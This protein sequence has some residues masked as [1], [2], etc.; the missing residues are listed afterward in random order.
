VGSVDRFE[1]F[2]GGRFELGVAL[3]AIGVPDFDQDPIGACGFF[4][5]SIGLKA[6]CLQSLA[7]R[8]KNAF[9]INRFA[10]YA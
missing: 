10:A 2:V 8:A 7:A 6:E 1:F 5:T 4:S 3:E 9:P